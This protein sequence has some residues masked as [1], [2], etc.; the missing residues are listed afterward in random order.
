MRKT[1]IVV[2]IVLVVLLLLAGLLLPTLSRAKESASRT[3][4]DYERS[5]LQCLRAEVET[6]QAPQEEE[7]KRTHGLYLYDCD[8]VY[9]GSLDYGPKSSGS[10]SGRKPSPR[11]R[12][13]PTKIH[14]PRASSAQSF[15]VRKRK[16]HFPS[17]TPTSGPRSRRSSRR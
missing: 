17:S 5:S 10:S 12:R 11:L 4:T 7:D 14:P 8:R 6:S 16:S 15:R 2:S 3:R 13:L 9:F 1:I